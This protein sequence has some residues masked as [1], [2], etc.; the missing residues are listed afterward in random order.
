MQFV[1]FRFV[2]GTMWAVDDGETNEIIS[3]FYRYMVD[4]AGSLDHTRAAFALNKTMKS[5]N[6]AFDQPVLYIHLGA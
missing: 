3:T 1:G 6:V 5:V 4:E 2:I